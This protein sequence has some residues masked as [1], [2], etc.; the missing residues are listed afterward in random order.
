MKRKPQAPVTIPAKQIKHINYSGLKGRIVHVPA[1]KKTKRDLIFVAGQHSSHERMY[2]FAEFLADYANVYMIDV[3][4]FGGM[5]SFKAIGKKITYD[6]YADY[7]YT[8]LKTQ[9]LNKNLIFFGTSLGGQFIT[10]MLQKHP[11]TQK[12]SLAF[13]GSVSFIAAKDFYIKQPY[14][15]MLEWFARLSITKPGLLFTKIWR[16]RL[17]IPLMLSFFARF[18][19]KMRLGDAEKR[20]KHLQM[21]KHLWTTND[22]ETHGRSAVMFFNEDLRTYSDELI[23]VSAHNILTKDDQYF[24]YKE[25]NKSFRDVFDQYTPHYLSWSVHMPSMIEDKAEVAKMIEPKIIDAIFEA[26]GWKK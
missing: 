13:I 12:W 10:R 26:E 20:R 23:H 9:R 19:K 18:K 17:V 24:N 3:P 22:A 16:N 4:G 5:K 11:D 7:L 6:N 25:V 14:R 1:N 8:V 15:F 2:P 21:E